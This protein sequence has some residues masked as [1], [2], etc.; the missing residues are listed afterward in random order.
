M[1][2]TRRQW[3]RMNT[4]ESKVSRHCAQPKCAFFWC[5]MRMNSLSN[6]SLQ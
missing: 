6:V 1:L 4:G 5:S 3:V 2:C